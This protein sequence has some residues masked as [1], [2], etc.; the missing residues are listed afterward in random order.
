[1][2]YPDF[3]SP[4]LS[5]SLSLF[6]LW[7][8]TV[9]FQEGCLFG[10]RPHVHQLSCD[11]SCCYSMPTHLSL[12]CVLTLSVSALSS[13]SLAAAV[14]HELKHALPFHS[15][16]QKTKKKAGTVFLAATNPC[17]HFKRI[18]CLIHSVMQRTI[19]QPRSTPSSKANLARTLGSTGVNRTPAEQGGSGGERRWRMCVSNFNKE[20]EYC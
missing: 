13:P 19:I 20:V 17:P 5:L 10:F 6:L 11:D 2:F 8:C 1:M 14:V 12:C 15:A 16:I 7:S 9:V 4:S 3:L 18:S